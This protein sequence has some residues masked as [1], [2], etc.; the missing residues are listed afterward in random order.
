MQRELISAATAWIM[1]L[2]KVS[3]LSAS[4]AIRLNSLSSQKKFLII[5]RLLW[6]SVLMGKRA[7]SHGCWEMQ[8]KAPR[9]VICA[10]AL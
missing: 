1:A 9:S 7:E 6:I 8:I 10:T 2:K 4:M 5:W 3:V